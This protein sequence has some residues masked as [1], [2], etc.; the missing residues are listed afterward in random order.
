[1]SKLNEKIVGK[2]REFGLT[3]LSIDNSTT[4]FLLTIM[5]FLFGLQSYNS[6]PKE[7]FPEV[8]FP[9]VFVNTPY[10]GNSAADIE[11]LI[12][13]P[14]E[15]EINTIIGLES[16][17]SMSIQDFSMVTVE[18]D[19]DIGMDEAVRKVK[20]AVDIAKS[21]LPTDLE[22]DPQ[23]VEINL[24]EIPIM[25]VNLS[26][27]FSVDQLKEY[28]E[29]L[30]DEIENLPQVS[31]AD[32]K[33][34]LEREV[35]IDVD[36]AKMESLKIS[37]NDIEN[38]ISSENLSMS[39][40]EIKSE[41][42][43]RAVRIIGQFENMDQIRNIIVKSESQRPVYLHNIATVTY[44]YKDRTSIARSDGL[45]VVSVD[46]IK[47]KGENLI[48]AADN[49]KAIL[50]EAENNV[51]PADLKVSVFN[52]QSHY[53]KL[54]ISNLENSII[55]GMILVIVV[56]LFFMGLRNASFVGIAIPLSML[57]GILWL[58]L[59]DVTLNMVVL[60]SLILALGML[61]DNAIVVVEN[62]FRYFQRGYP[63]IEAA[64]Y[65]AG[66]VAVP[67]IASTA[68]TVAAFLPIAFWPGLFGEFMK[69]LPITLILVLI[70]SLLVG[71]IINPVFTAR[72]MKIDVR[73]DNPDRRRK[74]RRNT[75]L[76]AVGCVVAGL[77]FHFIGIAW[78]RNLLGIAAII[79]VLNYFL[80]RPGSF[81]FQDRIMPALEGRYN[82]FITKA[83]SRRMPLVVLASTFGLLIISIVALT[84][85]MPKVIF[86]PS[87]DPLYIN[88]F[89]EL[90][91]GRDIHTTDRAVRAIEGQI[92][93]VLE[94]YQEIVESI[95]T[96]IGENTSDPNSPPEPGSSPH[97]ARITVT[98]VPTE[99]RGDVSTAVIMENIR[100]QLDD[101]PGVQIVVDQNA[102]GPPAGKPINIELQGEDIDEL[103]L[104]SE[105][106]I[107]FINRQNIGGIE[108]LMAD[109]QIG[110][111]ELLV[112][113]DRESARRFEL[114]TAMI[115]S[116]IRTSIYGREVS[117]YKVGEDEYPIMLRLDSTYRN[118]ISSILN[119]RITFRDPASGLL[120][121]VPISS[122]ADIEYSST[123]S[124]IKRKDMER[125]ITVYSNLLAG[126]NANEVVSEIQEALV[127]FE[128][129]EGVHY[130][131]TGEQQQQAEDMGFLQSAFVISIFLIF[132]ILV[133]QF[134][135]LISPFIIILSV[136]FS[137]IGVF[138]GY[139]VT[140]RDISVI[141][142]GV[143]I[144]SLAGIVVNNAI[145]LVDYT[146]LLV[147]RKVEELGN[148]SMWELDS[149]QVREMVVKGGATRLRPVLLTAITTILGL[150]P[151]AIGLNIDFFTL[152]SDLDPNIY[153]GGDN[154]AIWG[155]LAWTVIYGLVFS[156]FLTLIV[157]PA[158]YWLA[159]RL[160]AW[161]NSRRTP[162][163]DVEKK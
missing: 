152:I 147:R 113:I 72:F 136:L 157:V 129:P 54:L 137:T 76:F 64:K 93:E 31:E 35:K 122:V 10:F 155:P 71:L 44:G 4:V 56:L 153:I 149:S 61:V 62:V 43:L 50:L 49:V 45:P 82:N 107:N 24:S 77:L 65:G 69:Y 87:A 11:N 145:L 7:Q 68:T 90:P 73:S 134:N 37:F 111:P 84:L 88:V 33:G 125:V 74:N 108:E 78:A 146:D 162:A 51:F 105:N 121:Q 6:M 8:S 159:Y 102:S 109:V 148:N 75:L 5:I 139:A 100:S 27:D 83:L 103:A 60:F 22:T 52:D 36:L 95:L 17:T 80:L 3:S 154:T 104:L 119:Q 161:V 144:I 163:V 143:G 1:M 66:E 91:L 156:T 42:Y 138:L 140:G 53:T 47:R 79:T 32:I 96:Q 130:E 128:F 98:F 94:P 59:T 55:S 34:A 63:P 114:S 9:T 16:L 126:Y 150:V 133:S 123:Y 86:F 110:K 92:D 115:S 70:S 18:F 124:A 13:R 23:V 30:E 127:D 14:L 48:E 81:Y 135:S 101:I 39:G 67:I 57:T 106:L 158:M 99:E 19:E 20:D 41:G 97:K 112:H 118:S 46:V 2:L 58:Y 160:K 21:E 141:F 40:G 28:A 142:T 29:Y 120:T 89:V 85:N 25:S 117:K 131:F 151:L 116:A 38:A 12:T 132:L 26:G 15:K